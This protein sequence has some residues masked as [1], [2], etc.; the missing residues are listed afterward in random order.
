MLEHHARDLSGT[1]KNDTLAIFR[2]AITLSHHLVTAEVDLQNG[3]ALVDTNARLRL[4]S[5]H[6]LPFVSC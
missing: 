5:F 3:G 4:T 1:E 6:F 2:A